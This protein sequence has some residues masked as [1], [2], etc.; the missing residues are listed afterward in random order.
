[1]LAALHREEGGSPTETNPPHHRSGRRGAGPAALESCVHGAQTGPDWVRAGLCSVWTAGLQS[2]VSEAQRLAAG[3]LAAQH[4]EG[5]SLTRPV[6]TGEFNWI[7]FGISL[8]RGLFSI[9]INITFIFHCSGE[10]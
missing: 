10:F 3:S 8:A 7:L 4:S 6:T 9:S 1:M 5:C 2:R